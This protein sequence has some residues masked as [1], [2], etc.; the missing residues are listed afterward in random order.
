MNKEDDIISVFCFCENQKYV[1]WRHV[2]IS[3]SDDCW[4]V[5]EIVS[6]NWMVHFS[7]LQWLKFEILGSNS[8]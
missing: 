5:S 2:T 8:I 4:F 1:L 6:T 7:T 3:K